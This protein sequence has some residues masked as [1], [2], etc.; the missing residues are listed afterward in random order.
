MTQNLWDRAISVLRMTF[1]A[2]HAYVR[3]QEKPQKKT[4]TNK[5][6]NNQPNLTPKGMRKIR[7]N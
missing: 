1:I 3:K 6:K 4:Q 7:T 5:Q 2:T